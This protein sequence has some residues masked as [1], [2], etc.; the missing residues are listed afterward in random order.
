MILLFVH[1][2][3]YFLNYKNY[4]FTILDNQTY[5]NDSWFNDIFYFVIIQNNI[6]RKN[7][8]HSNITKIS[9]LSHTRRYG[10]HRGSRQTT[11]ISTRTGLGILDPSRNIFQPAHICFGVQIGQ[12]LI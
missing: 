11:W 10:S 9:Y 3:R 1:V 6:S 8:K 12:I 7:F 5:N 4:N 2:S